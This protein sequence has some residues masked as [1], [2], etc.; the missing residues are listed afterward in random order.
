MTLIAFPLHLTNGFVYRL[1]QAIERRVQAGFIVDTVRHGDDLEAGN[2]EQTFAGMIRIARQVFTNERFNLIRFPKQARV[3]IRP[4]EQ[5]NS[6]AERTAQVKSV[7]VRQ[8][9]NHIHDL[10]AHCFS[11][12]TPYAEFM[13]LTVSGDDRQR[14]T[15]PTF[16]IGDVTQQDCFRLFTQNRPLLNV[17]AVG[18]KVDR[19]P[20]DFETVNRIGHEDSPFTNIIARRSNE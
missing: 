14:F 10:L 17:K 20:G 1:I 12:L 18:I 2:T 7:G 3:F 8:V 19:V 15:K 13:L 9:L 5:N 11:V 16:N 6:L 4:G